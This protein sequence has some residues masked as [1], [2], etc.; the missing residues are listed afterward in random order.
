MQTNT[1]PSTEQSV[2]QPIRA[3]LWDFGG[4]ILS[5]PFDAFAKYESE[6]SLP[7]GLIRSINAK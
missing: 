4:V 3:I 2:Q 6:N 5:S 7:V 1:P